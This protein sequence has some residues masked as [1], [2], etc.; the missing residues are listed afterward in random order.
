MR[1]DE[2]RVLT[3]DLKGNTAFGVESSRG[4]QVFD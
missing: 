2:G 1:L 4:P 3:R